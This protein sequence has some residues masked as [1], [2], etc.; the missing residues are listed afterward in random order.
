MKPVSIVTVAIVAW[1]LGGAAK[2]EVI[3]IA[4]SATGT[5]RHNPELGILDRAPVG[6]SI[7]STY[8]RTTEMNREFRR[9]FL[10]FAVP[11]I[12]GEI[13]SAT[14]VLPEHRAWTS[15]PVPPD[16]HGLAYYPAD[17]TINTDDLDRPTTFLAS[18]ETDANLPTQTFSFDVTALVRDFQGS[19]LGFRIKL[20]ADP[21]RADFGTSGS[22]ISELAHSI[23]P[24]LEVTVVP[25]PST[26]ILIGLLLG[27][28][29]AVRSM[30]LRR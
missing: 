6:E 18:F 11:N 30:R 5:I 10:E 8:F 17:L 27:A 3:T 9:G 16:V 28:I 12:S 22:G 29:I 15:H 20:D 26:L 19:Q 23:P 24:H 13:V 7:Q 21:Q 4:P 14:L 1:I 2:A 25:E